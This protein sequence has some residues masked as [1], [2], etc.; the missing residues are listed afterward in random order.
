MTPEQFFHEAMNL[1]DPEVR[2]TFESVLSDSDSRQSLQNKLG[3]FFG[4][5]CEYAAAKD[6]ES[7]GFDVVM[8]P[9]GQ[10]ES[11]D[12]QIKQDGQ[13]YWIEHKNCSAGSYGEIKEDKV[14]L[15]NYK[16]SYRNANDSNTTANLY[17]EDETDSEKI[18]LLGVCTYPLTKEFTW[19]YSAYKDLPE[20][21]KHPGRI[22]SSLR[23]PIKPDEGDTWTTDLNDI[24]E[25]KTK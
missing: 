12:L 23:I 15:R 21:P 6:L 2:A 10:K 18:C 20:H 7:R 25:R 14:P 11:P 4:H 5:L 24:I 13:T 22:A 8:H 9:N 1:G 19:T 16:H 17:Y 3:N